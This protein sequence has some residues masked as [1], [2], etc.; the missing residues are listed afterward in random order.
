MTK[1]PKFQV[2]RQLDLRDCGPA[3]LLSI[4]RFYGGDSTLDSI[5]KISGTSLT[6]TTLLGVY[7]AASSLGFVAH[8]CKADIEALIEHK[9][10]C[11]LHVN[12]PDGGEHFVVL[13]ESIT[14]S[15]DFFFL[16][17][18]PGKG[19]VELSRSSLENIWKS[20]TCLLLEPGKKFEKVESK[21]SVKRA[22]IL[23][24]LKPDWPV[25]VMA[26][27]I[28]IAIAALGTTLAIV[29]QTLIDY[30]IPERKIE[31]LFIYILIAF[32]LLLFKE[33]LSA[34]RQLLLQRQSKSF[35]SG[36]S[37]S[38]FDNILELPKQYFDTRTIGEF[39]A[40]LND[41]S[42]IQRVVN[43][44]I[45]ETLIEGLVSLIS[46][47]F[48][49]SVNWILGLMS[50]IALPALFLILP[51]FSEKI[52]SCQ[53]NVMQTYARSESN[54]I[55]TI[56]GIDAIK[57]LNK[58][59]VFSNTNKLIYSTFQDAILALGKTQIK[60]TTLVG[61]L[62]SVFICILIGIGS[63]FVLENELKL[64]QLMAVIAMGSTL[65]PSISRIG[66]TSISI[67]EAKVALERMMEIINSKALKCQN[68]EKI[69][70]VYNLTVSEISFRFIGRQLLFHNVSFYVN[71]GEIISLVGESGKGKS[72]LAQII[73]KNYN[74]DSGK[75]FVNNDKVL[76]NIDLI[77]W[78]NACQFVPQDIQIFNAT[79]IE[80]IA[81]EDCSTNLTKVIDF[82][83]YHGFDKYF[84]R[85][86]QSIYT[87][88]GEEGINLSGGQKQ[89]IALARA[90]YHNPS[91]LIL[92]EITSAMDKELESFVLKLLQ[93]IKIK[94]AIIFISHKMDLLRVISN[95][96]YVLEEG[97]ITAEGTH[98]SLLLSKNLYSDYWQSLTHSN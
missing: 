64:G 74:P 7:Q 5:R 91:L 58:T 65:I 8:G 49:F 21:Q 19:M 32:L 29:S 43:V 93:K 53:R 71:K 12:L 75:I 2:V 76:D 54:F 45:S 16:I 87:P 13:F 50:L 92:D 90:I 78:N 11:I 63:Y 18:D 40:R 22:L 23:A 73:L 27:I 60:L 52:L 30:I 85:L 62:N 66:L 83:K 84:D 61:I 20:R 17:G 98:E 79:I 15:G 56:S 39:V 38:F 14:R 68:E 47:T 88:V 1:L 95:R 94:T 9:Q 10:P 72:T 82:L 86:P 33:G 96:I 35:N 77:S 89:L 46:I 4:L 24:N 25:I 51:L 80:N 42:R 59:S 28:G 36:L 67:S 97:T 48:I 26:I 44:L 69:E 57:G 37:T 6:G 34:V 81:F 55:S 3:C 31:K 70:Q 41:T